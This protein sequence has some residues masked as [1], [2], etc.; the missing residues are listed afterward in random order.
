M[1]HAILVINII[2]K[3]SLLFDWCKLP[4]NIYT[5][6]HYKEVTTMCSDSAA[7]TQTTHG[8]CDVLQIREYLGTNGSLEEVPG[9]TIHLLEEGDHIKL[10]LK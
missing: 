10:A 7:C 6:D 1:V 8:C 2:H 5:Y 9:T 4:I 3:N